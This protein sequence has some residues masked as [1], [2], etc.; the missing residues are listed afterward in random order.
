[1]NVVPWEVLAARNPGIKLI[2]H[3][4]YFGY[5]PVF[6]TPEEIRRIY[7]N[8]T[9]I[10]PI[11]VEDATGDAPAIRHAAGRITADTER[12]AANTETPAIRG[13]GE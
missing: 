5:L 2:A 10:L 3:D 4:G 11:N 6:Q 1:L 13:E 7:G 8:E 9:P 12:P